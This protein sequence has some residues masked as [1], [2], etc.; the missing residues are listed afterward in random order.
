MPKPCT[1]NPA[2]YPNFRSDVAENAPPIPVSST[3]S[4][5]TDEEM[6]PSE[7]P[8]NL[9]GQR[10]SSEMQEEI[11]SEYFLEKITGR[12]RRHRGPKSWEYLVR[13]I[14]DP[15][16]NPSLIRWENE[17]SGT[18]RLVQPAVIAQQWG[19]RASKH[20]NDSLSYENFARGLRYHYATGALHPV[21]ERNLV[22]RFGTKAL[23]LLQ[24]YGSS[25]S[26]PGMHFFYYRY[27]YCY[28]FLRRCNSLACSN[29]FW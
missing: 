8:L 25:V 11:N 24:K 9:S 21:S 28:L 6:S 12:R 5:N 4:V 1:G 27:I 10:N 20:A 29:D 18:F 19:R 15:S 13:L 22:Y 23:A 14:K 17:T 7:T 3:I 16:T 2:V 26:V